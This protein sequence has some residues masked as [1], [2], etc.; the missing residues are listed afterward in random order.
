MANDVHRS[1]LMTF[2]AAATALGRSRDFVSRL[3]KQGYLV[4]REWAG[5][6]W[7]TEESVRRA[8]REMGVPSEAQQARREEIYDVAREA[9][10]P[11]GPGLEFLDRTRGGA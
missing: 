11:V 2:N 7:V 5:R 8:I 6:T 1:G 9:A 3:A 4:A 10:S